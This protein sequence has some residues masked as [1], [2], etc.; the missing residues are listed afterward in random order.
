MAAVFG[1]I[2]KFDRDKEDWSNYV[3]RLTQGQFMDQS[4]LT[5][6]E[7]SMWSKLFI[8]LVEKITSTQLLLRLPSVLSSSGVSVYFRHVKFQT[9]HTWNSNN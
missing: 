9:A 1:K 4:Q 7:N 2:D 8:D 5:A 6:E 3:K